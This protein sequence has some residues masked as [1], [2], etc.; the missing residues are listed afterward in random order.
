[1]KKLYKEKK[2]KH[3]NTRR[4][5]RAMKKISRKKHSPRFIIAGKKTRRKIN[6]FSAPITFSVV[7]NSNET[8]SFLI[9]VFNSIKNSKPVFVN[10]THVKEITP[11]AILYLLLLIQEAKNRK[12]LFKGNAPQN[13]KAHDIFISSGFYQY[14]NS[15]IKDYQIP[16]DSKILKIKTGR[17]VNGYEAENIQNYLSKHV[18]HIDKVKLRAIYGILIE[19]MSNTNEYAGSTMGEKSWWTMALHDEE[20]NKVL[21]AFVD[22]GV[23]IP[24]TVR[25][26]WYD[27]TSD[28]ELLEKAAKGIYQMS[29]SKSK[30]RNKGLPQIRKYNE[31]GFIKNLVIVSNKGYYSADNGSHQLN[32]LFTGTMIAW[33]FV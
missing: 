7:H 9:D 31:D 32:N 26:K 10:L 6:K 22:N 3:F 21:F 25:K 24:S 5:K 18:K 16:N 20:T 30:T 29:G 33:E 23:G 11:D 13:K 14:V 2:Y 28:A 17:N 8:I 19:C 4:S 15:D 12:I 1:M 27:N